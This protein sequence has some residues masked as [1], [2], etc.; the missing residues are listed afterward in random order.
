MA[1][2][3]VKLISEITFWAGLALSAVS[4]YIL[5]SSSINLPAGVCPVNNGRPFMIAATALL[6]V[7][8]ITSFFTRRN[9]N[10]GENKK[11]N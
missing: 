2:R 8:F 7:S 6:A 10:K 3:I 11:N 5:V 4:V 1:S 9:K